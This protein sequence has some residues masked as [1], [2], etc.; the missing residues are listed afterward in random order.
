VA[1]GAHD[2]LTRFSL[3]A[4]A[5]AG[6]PVDV[7]AAATGEVAWTDGSTVFVDA[8]AHPRDQVRSLVVQASLLGAGSLE[9]E[10][11]RALARRPALARRYLALEGNR[12]LAAHDALLPASLRSLIDVA[13]AP[14]VDS[15]SAAL[16][17]ATTREVVNDP[18][19]WF[20]TIRP[21]RVRVVSTA[22]VQ[23]EAQPAVHGPRR[24]ED[25]V[26]R[27]LDDADDAVMPDAFSSPVGGGGPIGRLLSRML[28]PARST[29]GGPPGADNATHTS[30]RAT[31]RGRSAVMSVSNATPTGGVGPVE[32]WSTTYPEWDALRRRYRPNWCTVIEVTPKLDEPFMPDG[33]QTLRRALARL[34]L[35]VER[36]HRQLQG[37]DI[38]IDAAVEARVETLA[39]SAP[40]E[41]VYID[42]VRRRR[43]LS[44]LILLD[45]SGSAGEPSATGASVHELQ[46]RAAAALTV[47]LHDLG[48]RVALFAFHSQGRAAVSVVPIK[49][50]DDPLDTLVFRR[51]G[52]LIPGAYTRLGAAIRHGAAV[53]E[54][55]GGT[56]RRLLVVVSDGFAYDY[57][58]EGA[59]G[60]ADARHALSEARRRGTGCLCLSVGAATDAAALRRVFGTAAHATIPRVEQLP[61]VVGPLFRS[62]LQS[63]EVQR[64]VAQ[65]TQ[66]THE[67][68]QIDRRTR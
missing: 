23:T 9:F 55:H 5:I 59:Y 6:R 15:P 28:T 50:F 34:G 54:A 64:R 43:D 62:A 65:R 12:A 31:R 11:V 38:D 68:L 61:F 2:G 63:S 10:I 16:R 36:R 48:D 42:S 8:D 14:R 40:N 19:P 18:P 4:S 66:R 41:S 51:V 35:A 22:D 52:G 7:A 27:D 32:R 37:D 47:A 53:V 24:S 33:A 1:V 29:A 13:V 45:I 46:R 44:V 67:R 26:L 56:P 20:G 17:L 25:A 30:T 60:E 39:G 21:R 3:L 57:G 49:R 58:Y